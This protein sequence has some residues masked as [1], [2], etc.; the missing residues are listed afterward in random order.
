MT[1]YVQGDAACKRC[2]HWRP[3]DESEKIGKCQH[4]PHSTTR[5]YKCSKYEAAEIPF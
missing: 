5:D 2:E 1:E 4:R 3:R